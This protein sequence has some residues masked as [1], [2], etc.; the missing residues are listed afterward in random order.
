MFREGLAGSTAS[1]C[2]NGDELDATWPQ[3]PNM[4]RPDQGN[5]EENPAGPTSLRRQPEG[6]PD[7]NRK[8]DLTEKL[9]TKGVGRCRLAAQLDIS[10]H[11]ERQLLATRNGAS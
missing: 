11:Q 4:R 2:P 10:E 7:A 8:G 9:I 1:P 3:A 5:C 6:A